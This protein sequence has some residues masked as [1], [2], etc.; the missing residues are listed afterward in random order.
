MLRPLTT[1]ISSDFTPNLYA[2]S[3]AASGQQ[4]NYVSAMTFVI[5]AIVIAFSVVYLR[6]TRRYRDVS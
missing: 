1:A 3:L 5:G 4:M 6:V 2:Y